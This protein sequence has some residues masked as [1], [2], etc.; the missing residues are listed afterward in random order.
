MQAYTWMGI[1]AL[2][3]SLSHV[4]YTGTTERVISYQQNYAIYFLKN[5]IISLSLS[6][7][8]SL[9]KHGHT[10]FNLMEHL[11]TITLEDLY[12]S[13]VWQLS[14][15]VVGKCCCIMFRNF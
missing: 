2:L 13:D 10:K 3:P 15:A 12:C 9:A 1:D 6:K 11:C 7:T 4:F 14:I 5:K 8:W